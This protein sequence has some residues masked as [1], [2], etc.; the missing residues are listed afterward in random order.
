MKTIRGITHI[1]LGLDGRVG[2]VRWQEVTG[3]RVP[4]GAARQA[5]LEEIVAHIEAGKTVEFWPRVGSGQRVSGGAVLV[6]RDADG[7]AKLVEER[8]GGHR[9]IELPRF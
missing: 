7:R 6:E 8:Q 2:V 4:T 1:R 9:L 5:T 3:G